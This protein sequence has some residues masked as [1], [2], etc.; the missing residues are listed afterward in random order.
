MGV[1]A[2][3]NDGG[4]SQ[5]RYRNKP[6]KGC[7]DR[8]QKPWAPDSADFT[9][10]SKNGGNRSIPIRDDDTRQVL[11][12]FFT[13]NDSVVTSQ[14]VNSHVKSIADR[15]GL[16]EK[17]VDEEGNVNY[18][19]TTH[20][21]RDTYG[22]KLAKDGFGVHQIKDLMGHRGIEQALEYVKLTGADLGEEYDD[23][24]EGY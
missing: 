16:L 2:R 15:A 8:S 24:W 10:K 23:K 18:W 6:C 5:A 17:S 21:L 20:D 4:V 13:V 3:G 14:N 12:S 22:T 7:R 9:P 1:G 19:P 11:E